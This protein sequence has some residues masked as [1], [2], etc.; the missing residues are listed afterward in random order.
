MRKLLSEEI[1]DAIS[2]L[3][4]EKYP[5][6]SK[7]PIESEL[8]E[9]FSVSRTTVREAIK[10]L[11]SQGVLEI[12]RG[13]GTYVKDNT[14]HVCDPFGMKFMEREKLIREMGEFSFICQPGIAAFAAQ[15]AKKEDI[16]ALEENFDRFAEEWHNFKDNKKQYIHLRKLDMEFHALIRK[17][18]HNQIIIRLDSIFLEFYSIDP[19][20]IH[21]VEASIEWHP[22]IIDAIR[23]GD[24]AA[25]ENAMRRHI[26]SIN[27]H[28]D[29]EEFMNPYPGKNSLKM[30]G[31]PGVR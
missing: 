7:I 31:D 22:I 9:M 28:V 6:G 12:R 1:A 10:L 2:A 20:F 14:G 5:P 8:A 26:G 24:S 4:L 3:I 18:C 17:A 25:A 16:E 23:R 19:V 27:K 21:A 11:S 29:N 13:S 30:D 15:R